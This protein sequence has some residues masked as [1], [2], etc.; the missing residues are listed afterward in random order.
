MIHIKGK[1]HVLPDTL[2]KSGLVIHNLI[3][4]CNVVRDKWYNRMF[5]EVFTKFFKYII[6]V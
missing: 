6:N 1:G 4:T 2:S 3:F 5:P